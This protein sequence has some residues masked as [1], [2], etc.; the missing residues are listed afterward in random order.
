MFAIALGFLKPYLAKIA[1]LGAILAALVAGWLYV[2]H[3]QSELHAANETIAAD[4]AKCANTQLASAAKVN[5]AAQSAIDG[6]RIS[7]DAAQAGLQTAS[8][9]SQA[10]GAASIATITLQATQPGQDAP[11]APVYL[12][13]L[14]QVR[15][16]QGVAK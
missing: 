4:S 1:I 2:T 3:L 8:T 11:L 6:Q 15:A 5:A 14:A 16:A 7:L 10:Q 9:A 13:M 12:N